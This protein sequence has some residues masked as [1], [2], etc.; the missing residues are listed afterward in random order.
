MET[1]TD[2]NNKAVYEEQ[3][4]PLVQQLKNVCIHNNIPFFI[5]VPVKN[6]EKE[7]KYAYDG[8]MPNMFNVV[9][10]DD[11]IAKHLLVANGFD[12]RTGRQDA[13]EDAVEAAM[14]QFDQIDRSS[15]EF[16]A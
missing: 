2:F 16:E 8:L 13:F 15:D 12:V 5:G 3:I 9:L 6:N 14:L 4:A 11:R 10:K 1:A 7:T